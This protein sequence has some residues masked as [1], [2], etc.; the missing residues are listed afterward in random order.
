M[1]SR[2]WS[3]TTVGIDA[4]PVEI[5]TDVRAGLPRHRVVGLPYGAVCESLDRIRSAL[6][7]SGLPAP[8]GVITINLAPADLRKDSAS[9]D[10]PIAIGVL[11][12]LGRRVSASVVER[13]YILGELALDGSVRPVRGVLAMTLE[14]KSRGAKSVIVPVENGREAGVVNDIE[15]FAVASL[16]EA[17]D[18]AAGDRQPLDV[19]TKSVG[20]SGAVVAGGLDL[21]DVSGQEQVKRALEIAAAGGHN[22]L[23]VGP[24]G[25]GKTMMAR[26]L[27][28]ILPE[29]S[30]DEAVETTRIHSANGILGSGS[31]LLRQ[32][33]FRAPH[34]T[35]SDAG[36]CGGGSNPRPGEISLAH[37]G[38]LFLDELPEFKRSVLEV[39]RQPLEDGVVRISRSRISVQFPARFLL[40]ASMNPCPCGHLAGGAR[41]CIC[42]SSDILRYNARISGPLLDRIDMHVPV[43]PVDFSRISA[44]GDRAGPTSPMIRARVAA[45]RAEQVRRAG[46]CNALLSPAAV[47]QVCRPG[48]EGLT[49]L[50]DAVDRLGLSARAFTRV[51]KVART[52]ADLSESESVRPG[53]VAEAIQ[54]RSWDRSW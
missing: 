36:L 52:I 17:L 45:S 26:R 51:L 43:R 29:M 53:D 39:L 8:R 35:I 44:D 50:R 46:T 12:A 15:V 13:S 37:N 48:R 3:A 11:A 25:A 33:P 16:R 2:V 27:S 9:L 10:L 32:R 28:T 31:G 54:Y 40:V 23:L 47:R 21:S 24:P 41:E 18:A 34:H 22:M 30:V 7:N 38:V 14:A 6:A 19:R 4:V 42:R 1:H 5:E 20:R 49:M